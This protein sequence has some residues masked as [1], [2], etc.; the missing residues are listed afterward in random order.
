MSFMLQSGHV[1]TSAPTGMLD[2]Q[3][4]KQLTQMSRQIFGS[5]ADLPKTLDLI[6]KAAQSFLN[7]KRCTV[8]LV[9][10]DD[11]D[12]LIAHTGDPR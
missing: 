12:F 6:A 11:E 9:D 3:R 2:Y 4:L 7:L 8:W 5:I 10:P 1:D